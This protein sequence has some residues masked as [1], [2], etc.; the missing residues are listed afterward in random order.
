MAKFWHR[1]KPQNDHW[2]YLLEAMAL[3]DWLAEISI[4]AAKL[5]QDYAGC[6]GGRLQCAVSWQ[7]QH[8]CIVSAGSD[9]PTQPGVRTQSQPVLRR[10]RP[11]AISAMLSVTTRSA[12]TLLMAPTQP[13]QLTPAPAVLS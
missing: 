9:I 6:A 12:H 11:P 10:R 7:S 1:N 4:N 8:C 13:T 2:T 3:A 5:V